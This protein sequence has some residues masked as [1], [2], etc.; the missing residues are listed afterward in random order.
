MLCVTP[1]IHGALGDLAVTE[2]DPQ[3]FALLPHLS[4]DPALQTGSC[5]CTPNSRL[6]IMHCHRI[7]PQPPP[8]PPAHVPPVSSPHPLMLLLA[9]HPIA[10]LR[11]QSTAMRLAPAPSSS[12]TTPHRPCP[13]AT[14]RQRWPGCHAGR[15]DRQTGRQTDMQPCDFS[16]I[17][18]SILSNFAICPGG[19]D[20]SVE[21]IC[22][23][24]A[25]L[26]LYRTS[27]WSRMQAR[28]C[29]PLELRGVSIQA[30]GSHHSIMGYCVSDT[31][32][33]VQNTSK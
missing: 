6:F 13:G 33:Q 9:L 8:S 28:V 31:R 15:T 3:T 32:R 26:R 17:L 2:S 20:G 23:L 19:N 21:L 4:K 22:R 16:V 11:Y 12:Q 25:L 30:P 7:I 29:S 10:P 27:F 5:K 18:E 1:K 14:P 24:L